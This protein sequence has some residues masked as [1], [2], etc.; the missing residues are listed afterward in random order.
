MNDNI[1]ALLIF[2]SYLDTLGFYNGNWEFNFNNKPVTLK[3]AMLVQNE[4]VN[5]YYSLG[6]NKINI[7]K[8]NASD[9]TIMMIA[10]KVACDKNGTIDNFKNEYLNILDKLKDSKR[11]SGYTTIKSLELLKINKRIKYNKLMGGNGAAMRTA[12]I[13]IKY[14]NNL[15]DLIKKSISSS[16]LTHNYP[17]GFLGG[18][19]TALFTSY[20]IKNINPFDNGSAI[21]TDIMKTQELKQALDEY[22][23]DVAIGGARRD[24]EE[25]LSTPITKPSRLSNDV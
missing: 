4:I 22:K 25:A 10:T 18:L 5:N 23:F 15:D 13:G 11:A 9:D 20:A 2:G 21:H 19:V 8:W 16:R 1:K 24:E 7:S 6:G 3:E 12:Y 14:K 17:L